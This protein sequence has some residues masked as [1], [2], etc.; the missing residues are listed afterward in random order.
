M[1]GRPELSPPARPFREEEREQPSLF[2]PVL[3]RVLAVLLRERRWVI[4][5]TSIGV[6]IGLTLALLTTKTYTTS[7]SFVPQQAQDP[8]RGGLA[9]LAGQFGVSLGAMPG[10]TQ[11][12]QFYA[13]LLRTREILAPIATDSFQVSDA[14]TPRIKLP[15]FLG[16]EGESEAIVLD[17]TIQLLRDAV[18][19]SSVATRTTGVVTVSVKTK[20]PMVSLKIAERVIVGLNQFNLL[21]RQTQAAAERKFVEGRLE[22]SKASLRGAEDALQ[23]FLQ[24]N[25]QIGD[26]PQLT[27]ERERLQREVTL[28]QQL[29]LGLAQQYEDARIREVRD[30]PVV[31]VIEQP[32]IAVR[33]NP[34]GRLKTL[35]TWTSLA[36]LIAI[37]VVLAREALRRHSVS[38][39]EGADDSLSAEWQRFRGSVPFAR[40]KSAV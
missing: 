15:E 37:V 32:T 25:R 18:I 7:F 36:F 1:T 14:P 11:S 12:P 35:A 38:W 22:A 4:G 9:S 21:T 16:V 3:L 6:A 28:Q 31:T 29:V 23:R 34:R 30:T 26:S 20:S 17:N 10:L 13:D 19:T 24:S 8:S 27:F 40:P 2:P 33:A 39:E 5:M